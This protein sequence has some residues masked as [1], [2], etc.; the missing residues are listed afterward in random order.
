M[1]RCIKHEN[2]LIKEL[3]ARWIYVIVHVRY[4]KKNTIYTIH[5]LE[6]YN[7]G[8]IE[9]NLERCG[10]AMFPYLHCV[11]SYTQNKNNSFIEDIC[12]EYM[13]KWQ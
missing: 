11:C 2:S 4:Y 9:Y 6:L 7:V 12:K 3:F 13:K 1:Y 10:L 5:N 8:H